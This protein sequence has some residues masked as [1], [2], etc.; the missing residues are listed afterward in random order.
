VLRLSTLVKVQD[1][2][3]TVVQ[4][5]HLI[6]GSQP[7]SSLLPLSTVSQQT[8]S[9]FRDLHGVLDL[10]VDIQICRDAFRARQECQQWVTEPARGSIAF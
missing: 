6:T 10:W 9:P 3:E 7:V 4:L 2:N 1:R 5:G 8:A